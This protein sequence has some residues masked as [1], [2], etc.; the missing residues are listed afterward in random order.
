MLPDHLSARLNQLAQQLSIDPS[1][2]TVVRLS[3]EKESRQRQLQLLQGSW[4]NKHPWIV[5]DEADDKIYTITSMESMAQMMSM[6][7]GIQNELFKMKLEK[8]IWQRLPIDFYD[9][10]TVAIDR[11]RSMVDES[12]GTRIV[13]LDLDALLTDIKRNHPNLF[14]HLEHL[15]LDE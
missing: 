8:A 4:N 2:L 12:P 7:S 11:I 13:N 9:V 15:Q 3:G 10:W 14:Y 1:E 5:I 6:I